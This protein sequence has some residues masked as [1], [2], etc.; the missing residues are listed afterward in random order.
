MAPKREMLQ[1]YVRLQSL[2]RSLKWRIQKIDFIEE[3]GVYKATVGEKVWYIPSN[4]RMQCVWALNFMNTHERYLDV[5]QK[6]DTIMEIGAAT[7]EYTIPA[8]KKIGEKGQIHAFEV[9]PAS[10]LC[11]EKNLA[12]CN[13]VNVKPMKMAISDKSNKSLWLSFEK[14]GLSR[15]SFHNELSEKIHVKTIS[16]DDY[17]TSI[18]LEK[19]DVLK[20]TVNGHEPEVMKGAKNLLRSMRIVI[21]QSARHQEVISFLSKEGFSVKKSVDTAVNEVKIVLMERSL[22]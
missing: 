2:F 6:G 1:P 22:R 13:I 18:G 14:G 12:L 16:C 19:V 20:V 11:L 21:F 7:G 15:G 8:A 17:A 4:D 10:Y 3:D 9:E 5:L